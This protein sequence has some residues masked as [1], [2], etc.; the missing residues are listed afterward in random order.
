MVTSGQFTQE[1]MDFAEVA[2]I[3][4]LDG[5]KLFSLSQQVRRASFPTS[6]GDRPPSPGVPTNSP[7]IQSPLCPRCGATMTRRRA[8]QGKAEGEYF[9]GCSTYPNCR[10]TRAIE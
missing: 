5:P 9:W 7:P 10:G 3:R 6:R 1:A 4:L 8:K 2:G